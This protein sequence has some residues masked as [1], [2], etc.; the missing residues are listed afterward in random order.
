MGNGRNVHPIEKRAT[1]WQSLRDVRALRRLAAALLG[2]APLLVALAAVGCAAVAPAPVVSAP[3]G[4]GRTCSLDWDRLAE[5][6]AGWRPVS[7]RGVESYVVFILINSAHTRALVGI[8]DA[9]PP[10]LPQVG[11]LH[12]CQLRELP[13][14]TELERLGDYPDA[15]PTA[16]E[17]SPPPAGVRL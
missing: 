7:L 16:G 8:A 15:A 2:G 10:Q 11:R 12:F 17:P 4:G 3:A 14:Q 5:T 6:T 9:G 1:G 13:G